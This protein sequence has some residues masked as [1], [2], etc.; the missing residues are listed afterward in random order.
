V[1]LRCRVLVGVPKSG[2]TWVM[3]LLY[4]YLLLAT[5]G[6]TS[7]YTT[8]WARGHVKRA[9]FSCQYEW[10][11]KRRASKD[12]NSSAVE[13]AYRLLPAFAHVVRNS[14]VVNHAD[15]SVDRE[16]IQCKYHTYEI[17]SFN[18]YV[19]ERFFGI[20]MDR[21]RKRALKKHVKVH[22]LFVHAAH[23]KRLMYDTH[24]SLFVLVRDA[25]N[26]ALR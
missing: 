15:A 2:T 11:E 3:N 24:C 23:P 7:H 1:S 25:L 13:L 16:Q 8:R 22:K 4:T 26:Q 10:G 12:F 14:K 6:D 19:V 18:T 9:D 21:F 17:I 5:G 20:R